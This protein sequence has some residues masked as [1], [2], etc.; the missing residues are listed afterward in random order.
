RGRLLMSRRVINPQAPW[1]GAVQGDAFTMLKDHLLATS[2]QEQVPDA[3]VPDYRRS[4]SDLPQ[5]P[6]PNRARE[7]AMGLPFVHDPHD[8]LLVTEQDS[9][10]DQDRRVARVGV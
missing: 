9:E 5:Q 6:Q 8:P 10:V 4:E 2:T 7:Q 3:L 1:Q